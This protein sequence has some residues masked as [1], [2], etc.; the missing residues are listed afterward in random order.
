MRHIL[1]S[2]VSSENEKNSVNLHSIQDIK[3]D[4]VFCD[5]ILFVKL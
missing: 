2:E 3:V 5:G 4:P 1:Y